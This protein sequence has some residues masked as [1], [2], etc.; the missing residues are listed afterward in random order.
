MLNAAINNP[1]T[2]AAAGTLAYAAGTA[3]NAGK[4]LQL[5]I[6]GVTGYQLAIEI[7]A[8]VELAI[9]AAFSAVV[10]W[11]I[12]RILD[13]KSTTEKVVNPQSDEQP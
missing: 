4:T 2:G 9:V 12:R 5:V 3:N 13:R 8:P 11:V 6:D 10:H 7:S 1:G